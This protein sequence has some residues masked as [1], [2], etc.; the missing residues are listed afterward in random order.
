MS[1]R[2]GV[3]AKLRPDSKLVL[4]RAWGDP[5]A[6]L[7]GALQL[8]KGAGKSGGVRVVTPIRPVPSRQEGC[9]SSLTMADAKDQY[10]IIVGRFRRR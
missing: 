1:E 10:P 4:T 8:A 3:I 2:V 7:N 6:R 5:K 9:Q